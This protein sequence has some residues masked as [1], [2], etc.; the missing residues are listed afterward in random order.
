MV[1]FLLFLHIESIRH[2]LKPAILILT[3]RMHLVVTILHD[4]ISFHGEVTR[5][6]FLNYCRS[7][8]IPSY[9]H[10]HDH[11]IT[12][13]SSPR[14]ETWGV[15]TRRSHATRMHWGYGELRGLYSKI[16]TKSPL[17]E[18]NKRFLLTILKWISEVLHQLWVR[19]KDTLSIISLF[20]KNFLFLQILASNIFEF[21]SQIFYNKAYDAIPRAI[22]ALDCISDCCSTD[23]R[24]WKSTNG[25]NHTFLYKVK[26][27]QRKKKKKD[28]YRM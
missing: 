19:W 16:N 23:S 10:H 22:L 28:N 14:N 6:I 3:A 4:G 9:F 26:K 24:E 15:M 11:L 1:I 8:V 20:R 17:H 25:Y 2:I 18:R 13:S 27:K 21:S 12:S 7:K 5:G